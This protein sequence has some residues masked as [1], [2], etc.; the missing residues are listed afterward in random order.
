MSILSDRAK[1]KSFDIAGYV[2]A[3]RF[4]IA[5]LLV[6]FLA[7]ALAISFSGDDKAVVIAL[8]IVFIAVP[9]WFLFDVLLKILD[10]LG[11]LL[12]LRARE[13]DRN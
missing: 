3:A 13:A 11:E 2:A 8:T 6:M 12:I 4:A 10:T 5:V 7:L 1:E 9:A